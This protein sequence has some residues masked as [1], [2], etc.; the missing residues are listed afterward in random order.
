MIDRR[1]FLTITGVGILATPLA[2]EAQ[3]A[4]KVWRIGY[5]SNSTSETA[6]DAVFFEALRSLGYADGSSIS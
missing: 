4:G 2:G 6:A 3:Q 5:L 1:S